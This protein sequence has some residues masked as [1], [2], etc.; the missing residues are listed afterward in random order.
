LQTG[1]STSPCW[2]GKAATELLRGMTYPGLFQGNIQVPNGVPAG[3]QPIV[4]GV[5]G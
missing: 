3:D 4:L 1:F 5:A 2:S